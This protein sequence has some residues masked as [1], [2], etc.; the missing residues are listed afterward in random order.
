MSSFEDKLEQKGEQEV[1]QKLQGD[2]QQSDQ[3][4]GDQQQGDQQQGGGD[5]N[6][7]QDQQDQQQ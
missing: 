4:Q 1:E 2:K 5:P 7:M 6:A 3:Q